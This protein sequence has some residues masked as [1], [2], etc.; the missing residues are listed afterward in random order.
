MEST[1]SKEEK[2]VIITQAGN[3]GDEFQEQLQKLEIDYLVLEDKQE[4]LIVKKLRNLDEFQ[5]QLQKLEIDYLVLEDKQEFKDIASNIEEN[6]SNIDDV[7]QILLVRKISKMSEKF[8]LKTAGSLGSVMND[9]EEV[10]KQLID[11]IELYAS[12]LD[13]AGKSLLINYILKTRL[14]VS[15]KLRISSS[16]TSIEALL[17]CQLSV[18]AKLRISSSYT[19]IE[20]LLVDLKKHL[21]TKK[22]ASPLSIELHN[23]KQNTK[24]IE[25]Y[26]L[27][28]KK[29]ASPLSI[30][31]HNAKQNTKS[32]EEYGRTIE[33]LL[34][35]LCIAQSDGNENS[36]S[37][38]AA[39]K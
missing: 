1:E 6:K 27:L 36:L 18:S 2:E 26:D 20:A 38:I 34:V 31:L 24:S 35:N 16:Y 21:L 15:A 9:T 32:I 5:E 14:S 30:E 39:C 37:V 33:E 17:I 29:S 22:S 7:R 3:S 10:T 4:E 12:M 23:A 8:D 11:A 25:E 13:E 28:T 19:S